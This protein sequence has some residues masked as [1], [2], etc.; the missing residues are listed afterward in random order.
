M[1]H[2]SD[3]IIVGRD[4]EI[5]FPRPPPVWAM[6]WNLLNLRAGWAEMRKMVRLA[7]GRLTSDERD[8]LPKAERYKAYRVARV[9]L[10]ILSGVCVL[11]VAFESW[12]PLMLVGLPTFYGAWLHHLLSATQHAG[13][14]EDIPDYRMNSRTVFMNPFFRF[15]YSNMNYHLEH[16]MFPLVPFHALPELHREIRANC[17]PPYSSVLAAYR[18]MIPAMLRQQREPGYFVRRPLPETAGIASSL[19]AEGRVTIPTTDLHLSRN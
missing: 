13:L 2:H 18:E 12:L 15:I 17:P 4:P 14:A 5:A 9:H 6:A 16:H 8:F 19:P 7:F 10:A 1:R 3:T 11:S